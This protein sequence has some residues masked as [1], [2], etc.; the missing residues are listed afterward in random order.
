MSYAR[1][2]SRR[3]SVCSV[4]GLD[5]PHSLILGAKPSYSVATLSL[6]GLQFGIRVRTKV[7]SV[8]RKEP[9]HEIC[10]MLSLGCVGVRE[11]EQNAF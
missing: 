11:Q 2:S 5:C 9:M 3:V 7:V 1:H 10:M 6:L 8:K 4:K